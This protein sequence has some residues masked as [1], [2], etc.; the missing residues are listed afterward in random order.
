MALANKNCCSPQ[1]KIFGPSQFFGWA[2]GR[3]NREKRIFPPLKMG[4]RTK[5][6]LKPEVRYLIS[7][8]WFNSCNDNL[9]SGITFPLHKSQVHWSGLCSDE[10]AVHS[11]LLLCL[12]R[13]VAKL[14]SRLLFYSAPD[15][16]SGGPGAQA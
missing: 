11:C 1:I 13:Q 12:Q 15:V 3:S 14:A 8:T 7:I 6:F 2:H 4:L 9:F 5:K 10:F 16:D